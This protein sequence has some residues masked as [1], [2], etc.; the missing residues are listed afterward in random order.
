MIGNGGPKPSEN[1]ADSRQGMQ[2]L[3]LTTETLC[4]AGP[5]P[6]QK[7]ALTVP[8]RL[9]SLIP[10]PIEA[11]ENIQVTTAGTE[12]CSRLTLKPIPTFAWQKILHE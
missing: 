9:P 1:N 6:A 10:A 12:Q 7:A 11:M 5:A 3:L 2:G 4:S 8:K